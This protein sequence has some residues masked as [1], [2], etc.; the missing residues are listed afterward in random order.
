MICWNAGSWTISVSTS[1]LVITVAT[2]APTIGTQ[3]ARRLRFTSSSEIHAASTKTT[4]FT[5]LTAMPMTDVCGVTSYVPPPNSAYDWLMAC[6]GSALAPM[7]P[8]TFTRP[9]A[10]RPTVMAASKRRGA[11]RGSWPAR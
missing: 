1:T 3:N 5:T 11:R 8:A 7:L 6:D 10:S 9:A 2:T 4:M